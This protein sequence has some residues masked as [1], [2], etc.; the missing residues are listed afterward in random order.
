MSMAHHRPAMNLHARAMRRSPTRSEGRLWFWLRGR[1][2]QGL[3]FKRQVPIGRYIADFYCAE[4]GLVIEVDGRHHATPW[5]SR[6][7]WE[8]SRQLLTERGIRV[9]RITNE[10]LIRNA[11]M[12]EQQIRW[13]I[14]Q[15]TGTSLPPVE[16]A[17][18][19]EDALPHPPAAPSPPRG[20]GEGLTNGALS[21]SPT[22]TNGAPS[23]SP[24][25]AGEKVPEGR[26]R[27]LPLPLVESAGVPGDAPPHPP[28]APSPPQGGGEGL[29]NGAPS[30]SPTLTNGAISRSPTLAGEKM[31]EGRMRGRTLP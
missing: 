19:L 30:S 11:P 22:L 6:Y 10:L 29:T 28:A 14:E 24:P 27:G 2:F 26:M 15:M 5:V 13:V 23:P 25:L 8:R 20:G 21:S 18:G 12:V 7:D 1:R 17:D 16:T 4:L 31:P 3:K 9:M